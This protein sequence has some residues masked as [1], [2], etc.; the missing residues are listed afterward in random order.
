MNV[1]LIKRLIPVTSSY[2]KASDEKKSLK[3][4][5]TGAPMITSS[6]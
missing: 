4:K 2:I 5:V 3:F 1:S 6:M